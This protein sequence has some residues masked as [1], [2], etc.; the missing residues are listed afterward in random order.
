[1]AIAIGLLAWPSTMAW[2]DEIIL[3]NGDRL[4]GDIVEMEKEVLTLKTSYAHDVQVEW[5]EVQSLTSSQSFR[6]KT[7][8]DTTVQGVI[9]S[10][11][12]GQLVVSSPEGGTSAPIP[13]ASVATI[14]KIESVERVRYS[15]VLNVGGSSVK[16]NSDT[17]A[18][19]ASALFS[20]RADQ[21]RFGAEGKYNYAEQSQKITVRNS[22]FRPTYDYFFTKHVYGALFALLE[23]DTLQDLRLRR[24]LGAGPGYQFIDTRTTQLA[25]ELG[26]ASVYTDWKTRA[27]ENTVAAR[28]AINWTTPVIA[29]RLIFFH[30]QEGYR[31]L[32]PQKAVRIRADQGFR[33]PIYKH[34]SLNLEYDFLYNS[35]PA[36]GRQTTDQIYIFG[37]SYVLPYRP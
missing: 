24:T 31:D 19:N 22:L 13:L 6:I 1:M 35:N 23:Q 32:N 2:A 15:G 25:A 17:T 36:P 12:P 30:R 7:V 16:G 26:L 4:S 29:D 5:K 11:A 14:E 28:W 8:D 20:L 27:D 34:F 21:H 3:K 10:P 18:V 37:L 33:V 9:S